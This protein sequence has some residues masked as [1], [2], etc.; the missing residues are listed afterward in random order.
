M[1]RARK[2]ED[3]LKTNP[4]VF[5]GITPQSP[6]WPKVVEAYYGYFEATCNYME[7]DDYLVALTQVYSSSLAP[8]TLK[9][10][11]EFYSSPAGKKLVAAHLAAN[12]VLQKETWKHSAATSEKADAEYNKK[13]A[14]LAGIAQQTRARRRVAEKPWWQFWDG[15]DQ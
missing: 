6:L 12:I 4:N 1:G 2:P 3:L 9:E 13:I 10:S 5:K 15:G 7:S 11:T 14:E 8:D